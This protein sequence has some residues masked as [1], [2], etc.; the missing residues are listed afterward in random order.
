[1]DA[2]RQALEALAAW[3]PRF[4]EPGFEFARWFRLTPDAQRFVQDCSNHGWIR[5]DLDWGTWSGTSEAARLRDDPAALA[6]ASPEDQARLLTA[7]VRADRFSGGELAAAWESGLLIR[8]VQ[9]AAVLAAGP[10]LG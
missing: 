5:G 4:A 10:P 3:A 2:D 9:R 6:T 7:V 8:I 1:M